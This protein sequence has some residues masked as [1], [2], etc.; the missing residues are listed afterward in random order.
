[1]KNLKKVLALVLAL[2][3][4]FGL[5]ATAGAAATDFNDYDEIENKEAVEV[6]N[7]LN[8]IG[9]HDTGDFKPDGY[10]TRA[11]MCKMVAYVMNGGKE[12]VLGST[13]TYSYTDT[14]Y[15]WAKDYIE[16]AT[17]MG[18]VGGVGGG[19]FNPDGT[20][21]GVQAAKM[22]LTAMGYDTNVFGFGGTGWD[23]NVNRY[24]NETGLYKNLGDLQ[25][26][27]PITRD[28]AAQLMYNAIQATMVR[29]SWDQNLENGTIT[30]GYTPWYDTEFDANG[31]A[32][33][34]A[35]TLLTEK[36]DGAIRVGYLTSFDYDANKKTWT[37]DF[38]SS[39]AYFNGATITKNAIGYESMKS[40][41]ASRSR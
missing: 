38:D 2:S 3:T 32:Y 7:A 1:M 6:M 28:D 36:F 23:V 21:T 19:K 12:P 39:N 8:V 25:P 18:I 31:N 30:E 11:E 35:H 34:V 33:T 9:G 40:A 29:K 15:S 27:L 24:A 14:S 37:Y 10:L 13:G 5:S 4:V 16:Y 22:M 41:L 17:S 26:N 20:L